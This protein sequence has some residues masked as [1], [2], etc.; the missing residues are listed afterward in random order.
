M[1]SLPRILSEQETAPEVQEA[2]TPKENVD[3]IESTENEDTDVDSEEI[4]EETEEVEE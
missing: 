1:L 4:I 3:E 2:E